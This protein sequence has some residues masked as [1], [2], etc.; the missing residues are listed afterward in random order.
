MGLGKVETIERA[1]GKGSRQRILRKFGR[2]EEADV[3][4][5]WEMNPFWGEGHLL[6]TEVETSW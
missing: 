5:Q 2:A 4:C 3:L 1:K 6:T